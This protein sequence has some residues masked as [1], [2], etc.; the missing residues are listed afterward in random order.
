MIAAG[1]LALPRLHDAIPMEFR[2]PGKSE[3]AT[4]M[5]IMLLE[6][7]LIT[8]GMLRQP[9]SYLSA[10]AAR[11]PDERDLSEQA[12][13]TWWNGIQYEAKHFR[14]NMHVQRLDSH[15]RA[16]K[17]ERAPV[18]WFCL[19][20]NGDFDIPR[21]ALGRRIG[22]LEA[23]REGLGQTALSVLLEA[24]I[25]LPDALDPWRAVNFAEWLHWHSSDSDEELLEMLREENDYLTTQEAL[26]DD[27]LTRAQFYADMPRWV[28][29]PHRMLS[30][31]EM[32]ATEC[33]ERDRDVIASCAA[34][35]QF[36]RLAGR[37]LEPHMIGCHQAGGDGSV[38][39]CMVLLWAENDQIGRV[40]D[41]GINAIGESGDCYEMIDA[42]PV[43][44]TK[45]NF[46]AFQERTEKMMQLAALT[47]RLLDLIGDPL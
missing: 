38:D 3:L 37:A 32:A 28:T 25:R 41:D 27:V 1:A 42:H 23:I 43:P 4:P 20:R 11:E 18:G 36:I 26:D 19:T 17:S 34:I 29:A 6:A 2:I 8:D 7:N 46:R 10:D 35:S 13:T 45:K 9:P 21:F 24:T 16:L 40:L 14:W 12:M 15:T 44:L 5:A 22:E 39:G 47:E 31:D 30:H 33:G